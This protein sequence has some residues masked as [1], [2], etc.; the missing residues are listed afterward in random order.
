MGYNNEKDAFILGVDRIAHCCSKEEVIENIHEIHKVSTKEVENRRKHLIKKFFLRKNKFIL[1]IIAKVQESDSRA[2]SFT[3]EA[4]D[5]KENGTTTHEDNDKEHTKDNENNDHNSDISGDEDIDDEVEIDPEFNLPHDT[6]KHED[7]KDD[8][9]HRDLTTKQTVSFD[10]KS[11]EKHVDESKD[12]NKDPNNNVNNMLK[13]IKTENKGVLKKRNFFGSKYTKHPKETTIDTKDNKDTNTNQ[14]ANKT[15]A[16]IVD[17]GISNNGGNNQ[18]INNDPNGQNVHIE[19]NVHSPEL[20]KVKTKETK[21]MGLMNNLFGGLAKKKTKASPNKTKLI[22]EDEE[23]ANVSKTKK[24][25]MHERKSKNLNLDIDMDMD[26]SKKDNDNSKKTIKTLEL[27]NKRHKKEIKS[28]FN[29]FIAEGGEHDKEV[30]NDNKKDVTKSDN[31]SKITTKD[32]SIEM[33]VID[34]KNQVD[35]SVLDNSTNSANNLTAAHDIESPRES[36][37]GNILTIV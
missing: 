17:N 37:K 9:G 21:G 31:V 28:L 26:L 29:Q 1:D 3:S 11:I 32:A 30:I 24:K 14:D 4:I 22:D 23:M 12:S 25:T 19:H 7:A 33:K 27:N 2:S 35:T 36:E 10:P 6:F 18:N 13:R 34:P 5:N 8:N 16:N 15:K 20:N